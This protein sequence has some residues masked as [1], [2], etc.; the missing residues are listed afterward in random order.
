MS[1]EPQ[2]VVVLCVS[3]F[4]PAEDERSADESDLLQNNL[5]SPELHCE[6]EAH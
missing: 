1:D 2:P 6:L 4:L 3:V 5:V